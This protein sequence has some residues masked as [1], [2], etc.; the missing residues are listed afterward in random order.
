MGVA[1][2]IEDLKCADD[3]VAAVKV[4]MRCVKTVRML[5]E[6]AMECRTRYRAD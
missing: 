3:G 2:T 4:L 1:S 6:W 5:D